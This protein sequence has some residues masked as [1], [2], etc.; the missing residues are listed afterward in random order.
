MAENSR[1]LDLHLDSKLNR[2]THI[3]KKKEQLKLRFQEMRLILRAKSHI[4]L[5]NKRFLYVMMLRSVWMYTGILLS[6]SNIE[7]RKYYTP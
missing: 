2:T 5:T 4:S 6:D 1:Y 7:T 3:Q